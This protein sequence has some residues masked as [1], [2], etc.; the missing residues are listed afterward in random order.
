MSLAPLV[1][2][3]KTP[4]GRR[5][6]FDMLCTM[7]QSCCQRHISCGSDRRKCAR[8]W[9]ILVLVI[10]F[11]L[12]YSTNPG[13]VKVTRRPGVCTCGSCSHKGDARIDKAR[14]KRI[15][16]CIVEFDIALMIDCSTK[17]FL[18]S[19]GVNWFMLYIVISMLQMFRPG[20]RRHT[21]IEHRTYP[22]LLLVRPISCCTGMSA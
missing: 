4:T 15:R 9:P 10:C 8:F 22:S 17:H 13:W 14:L 1:Y 6:C 21:S 18:E 16:I 11:N 5:T 19:I 7:A 20:M 2:T 3:T 12:F